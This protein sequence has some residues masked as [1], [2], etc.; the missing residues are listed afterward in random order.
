MK[1]SE[2]VKKTGLLFKDMYKNVLKGVE[3]V[4]EIF[5]AS[6]EQSEGIN[7]VNK[8]VGDMDSVAQQ[9]AANAE[10]SASAAEEM[11]AQTEKLKTMIKALNNMVGEGK[12]GFT[13]QDASSL[14]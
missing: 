11:N 2:T 3:L 13:M 14:H 8:A 9:N 5:A 12:V 10:E 7:Q 4:A 1:A 6:K